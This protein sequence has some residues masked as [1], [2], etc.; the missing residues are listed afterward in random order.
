MILPS[1]TELIQAMIDSIIA[2]TIVG[3]ATLPPIIQ[4]MRIFK[5]GYSEKINK[6]EWILWIISTT[7]GIFTALVMFVLSLGE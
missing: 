1:T 7:W 5:R 2:L 3:I 6:K 4:T